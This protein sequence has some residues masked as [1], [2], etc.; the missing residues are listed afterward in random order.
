MQSQVPP[1]ASPIP[2]LSTLTSKAPSDLL[3]YSLVDILWS[4]AYCQRWCNGEA[5]RDP[6]LFLDAAESLVA[7]SAALSHDPPSQS[8]GTAISDCQERCTRGGASVDAAQLIRDAAALVGSKFAALA[9]LSDAREILLAAHKELQSGKHKGKKGLAAC[10]SKA[11]KKLWFILCWTQEQ[12][13]ELFSR[14]S[15]ETGALAKEE[16]DHAEL[17]REAQRPKQGNADQFP[18]VIG[19]GKSSRQGKSLV[20]EL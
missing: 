13:P 17:A 12:P 6:S 20:Q 19:S 5:C 1:I 2:A 10:V 4:Y 9:G 18:E 3:K 16:E 11:E 15:S 7:H 8:V 14:L